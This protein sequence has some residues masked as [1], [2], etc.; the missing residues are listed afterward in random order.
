MSLPLIEPADVIR[1]AGVV[2]EQILKLAQSSMRQA[3]R[4]WQQPDVLEQSPDD[5]QQEDLLHDFRVELRRLRVWVH[6]TRT[7]VRTRRQARMD[8][9]CFA[10]GTNP[11]RD[12]EVILGLL[13]SWH[14]DREPRPEHPSPLIEPVLRRINQMEAKTE[15]LTLTGLA[16]RSRKGKH[17]AFGVWL[18]MQIGAQHQMIRYMS[19][20]SDAELHQARIHVKHLRY[21]IEPLNKFTGTTELINLL[22]QMQNRLGTLHDLAV[23]RMSIPG[24]VAEPLVAALESTLTSTSGRCSVELKRIFA[25]Q[26]DEVV[27]VIRWQS[28]RYQETIKAWQRER[29]SLMLAL[30]SGLE[31]LCH[32]LQA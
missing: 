23:L 24:F 18:S 2:A 27:D 14:A 11:S 21:L 13:E 1:P 5:C 30:E 28:D 32:Q 22:K 31:A 8:L 12:L 19:Q 9:R 17:P 26:R 3:Y 20:Q 16:P 7:L 4:L 25:G 15:S 29:D 10:Q 6:Q